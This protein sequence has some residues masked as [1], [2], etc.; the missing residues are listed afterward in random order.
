M[1]NL[2]LACI[3]G[4]HSTES[5]LS[6]ECPASARTFQWPS[7]IPIRQDGMSKAT[8]YSMSHVQLR[9]IWKTFGGGPVLRGLDLEIRPDFPSSGDLQAPAAS[10]VVLLGA[11]GCGKTTT[12]RIIAGLESADSGTVCINGNP[13]DSVPPRSRDVS[14]VF[15][16][17]SLYPHLTI[18]N[19]I[20]FGLGNGPASL[21]RIQRAAEIT[22]I[23]SLL[24]RYPD[25][26]SGG[27]LRR[28]AIAKGIARGAAIRLLDEP[29]SALD[30]SVRHELAHDIRRWHETDPGIT[31]HVT[32]DGD[33][34][35]RMADRIAVM[36][37]GVIV[38]Y[39]PPEEV[40]ANPQ[41]IAAARSMGSPPINCI[42]AVVDSGANACVLMRSV[43]G[44]PRI[45]SDRGAATVE[46]MAGA[47]D[48]REAGFSG[49]VVV[50][51]RPE[52]LRWLEPGVEWPGDAALRIEAA[53]SVA[54]LRRLARDSE[55]VVGLGDST[56]VA[57]V[58]GDRHLNRED[59]VRL[60]A[61][62]KELFWFDPTSGLRV[63]RGG[64]AEDRSW[65]R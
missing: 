56:I 35:M 12:L 64:R 48:F 10:Y 8:P 2:R 61:S 23:Q 62:A 16:Q 14:Y 65:T 37:A 59:P 45:E 57:V 39:A 44:G 50:A 58:Q 11:S 1:R 42:D 38:Q 52:K 31:I 55:L 21:A 60:V 43:S 46:W 4:F 13:V 33:E 17:N 25:Q 9:K 26:L 36:D 49:E 15:Q 27:E 18:A 6:I 22:K 47:A 19:S 30:I 32:H 28:A 20:R 51:V 3:I 41:T 24:D 53:A 63:D 34:A 7:E 54:K 5:R 40:F 29:L